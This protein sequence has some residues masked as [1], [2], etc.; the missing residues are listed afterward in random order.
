VPIVNS[1][2]LLE[3]YKISQSEAA[4][5][6]FDRY[7][8]RLI[9]LAHSRL[10]PK[11]R[12]RV[13][14]ADIVQSAYRSFFLHAKE[15][16]YHVA[17]SGDLWRL[18]ASITLNKLHSQIERQ[19]AAKRSVDR[20]EI[21]EHSGAMIETPEPSPAEVIAIVEELQILIGAL[22]PD[23]Q[24]IL[25]SLLGGQSIAAIS[26]STGKSHRTTRRRLAEVER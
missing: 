11:L 24:L 20:E 14:A 23:Q 22:A 7:L 12:R 6:I 3:L 10:G 26:A 9:S 19:T 1:H 5:A 15:G 13:D 2:E 21:A 16:E 18:L 8:A 25:K 17:E 4:T